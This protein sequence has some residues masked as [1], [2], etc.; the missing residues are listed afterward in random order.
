[1]DRKYTKKIKVVIPF[2]TAAIM[3]G[4]LSGCGGEDI[5]ELAKMMEENPEIVIEL[6]KPAYE[7]KQVGQNNISELAW[8]QLDQLRTYNTF[9]QEMDRILNIQTVT[10]NNVNGKSGSLYVDEQENR[11]GNTTLKDAF[12]NKVFIEKYWENTEITKELTENIGKAYDDVEELSENDKLTAVLNAYYNLLVDYKNPDSFNGYQPVTREQFMS[13]LY[14]MDNP[15]NQS[16]LNG[17]NPETDEF[18]KATGISMY[19]AEAKQMA[20]YSFLDYKNG[21]L[22][23]ETIE[24][25]ISRIEALYMVVQ[26]EFKDLY[27]KYDITKETKYS[28]VKKS[29]DLTGSKKEND[30]EKNKEKEKWQLYVLEM[31]MDEHGHGMQ[32]ELY[33]AA[34]VSS[35]LNLIA[36]DKNGE[37]RWD[38]PISK[39]EVIKLMV[40]VQL[41]KNKL[42]GYLTKTEFGNTK[43]ENFNIIY[44]GI[45]SVGQKIPNETLESLLV[46]PAPEKEKEETKPETE[47]KPKEET[48]ESNTSSTPASKPVE[49]KPVEKPVQNNNVGS[50]PAQK[51]VESKPVEKPV[52]SKPVENKPVESK[53]VEKPVE[54]KPVENK[55]VESKP[56]KTKE[57]IYNELV[58]DNHEELKNKLDEI[59]GIER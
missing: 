8:I 4:S 31:M 29:E 28:D 44:A 16:Y 38:E 2:L 12:R 57:E 26:S 36:P 56:D 47:E 43:E 25:S 49:N 20:N 13:A 1:M 18:V 24:D 32:E 15:V 3:V 53:P 33:K 7:F 51:P 37:L 40:N 21:S 17:W 42:E 34:G 55:P 48:T 45:N 59:M 46:R 23:E 14:R 50:K 19:T 41:V 22:N 35:D 30:T 58:P 52:E 54:S 39:S 11:S 9:R 27:D 6:E 5:S 10:Q